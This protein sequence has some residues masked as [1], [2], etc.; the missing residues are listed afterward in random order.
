MDD[1]IETE[2]FSIDRNEITVA[3]SVDG[4]GVAGG[5]NAVETGK[6]LRLV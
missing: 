6:L 2:S 1:Q 4:T 5:W 3:A